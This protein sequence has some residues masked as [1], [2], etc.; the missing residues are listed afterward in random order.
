MFTEEWPC[1]YVNSPS[2]P[3]KLNL[4]IETIH[5]VVF[6]L[7]AD[8]SYLFTR[9]RYVFC[10]KFSLLDKHVILLNLNFLH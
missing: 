4:P 1:F 3:H 7:R 6:R 2:E 9:N 10:N 8:E 5:E